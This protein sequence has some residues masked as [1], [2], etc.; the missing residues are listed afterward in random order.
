MKK[1]SILFFTLLLLGL[2]NSCEKDPQTD[3]EIIQN[4][5]QQ[6]VSDNNITI[7]DI[8][9]IVGDGYYTYYAEV[10]FTITGGFVKVTDTGGMEDSFSL[11][12]LSR[13][14]YYPETGNKVI[15]FFSLSK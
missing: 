10:D 2:T 14:I 6:F 15:L 1:L 4:E 12:Q 7:C 3:L 11:L 5:L 8:V 13:Y 9:V